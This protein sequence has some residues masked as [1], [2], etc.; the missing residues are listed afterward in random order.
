MEPQK[1]MA[2][3]PIDLSAAFH[4]VDHQI[5]LEIWCKKF[6]LE[7]TIMDWFTSYL[8]DHKCN[9]WVGKEYSDVKT[10]TSQSYK[11]EFYHPHF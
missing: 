11:K 4:M 10:I 1:I 7:G 8:H 9:V 6:G 3:V 5:L 2:L